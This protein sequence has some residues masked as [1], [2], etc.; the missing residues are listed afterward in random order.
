MV[1]RVTIFGGEQGSSSIN[2]MIRS[3]L[4]GL[5]LVMRSSSEAS[6]HSAIEIMEAIDPDKN[7]EK[8]VQLNNELKR[9][10]VS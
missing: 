8:I 10:K 9:R 5:S 4:E 2:S 6:I 1:S 7:A 3:N